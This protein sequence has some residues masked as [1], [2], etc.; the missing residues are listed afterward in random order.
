MI[1]VNI[2]HL[3]R[4][5][6]FIKCDVFSGMALGIKCWHCI[7]E[8]CHL[9]PSENYKAVEKQ[10]LTG[11]YCQVGGRGVSVGF[12]NSLASQIFFTLQSDM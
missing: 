3:L 4:A 7:S 9:D 10:C 12:L 1:P 11:Q 6:L 2:I 5:D 8:D